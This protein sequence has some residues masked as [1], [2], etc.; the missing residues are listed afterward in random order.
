[1]VHALAQA[2]IAPNHRKQAPIPGTLA[3]SQPRV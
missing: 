3:I 2:R 1:M